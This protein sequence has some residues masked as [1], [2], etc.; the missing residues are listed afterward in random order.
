MLK[1]SQ[2]LQYYIRKALAPLTLAIAWV[3]AT[4]MPAKAIPV[5]VVQSQ[6]CSSAVL[7]S[8]IPA[9]VPLNTVTGD[10]CSL[11]SN[12]SFTTPVSRVIQNSTLINPT[13]INSRISDSVLINPVIINSP[14]YSYGTFGRSTVIYNS[15]GSARIRISR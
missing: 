14:S 11:S 7:G 13:I 5:V 2:S 15:P 1:T 9:P 12:V 8:P 6:T 4:G 3:T 10:P